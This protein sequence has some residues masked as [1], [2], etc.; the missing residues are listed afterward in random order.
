MPKLDVAAEAEEENEKEVEDGEGDAVVGAA[1]RVR[2]AL[3]DDPAAASSAEATKGL[4]LRRCLTGGASPE[5][6][7]PAAARRPATPAAPSVCP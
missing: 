1:P 7:C 3:S 6:R 4:R 2:G 5:A